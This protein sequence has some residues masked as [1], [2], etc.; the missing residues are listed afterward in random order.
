MCDNQELSNRATETAASTADRAMSS[1]DNNVKNVDGRQ[2][3]TL[4]LEG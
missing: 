2:Y 4:I 3:H 1:A